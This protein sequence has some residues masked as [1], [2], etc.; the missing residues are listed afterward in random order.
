MIPQKKR[1]LRRSVALPKQLV[2]DAVRNAPR[3]VGD[4]FNR[5]V[6]ISL[7]EYVARRKAV[8]FEQAM[9]RMASDPA[10]R[11]ECRSIAQEFRVADMDGLKDD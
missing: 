1:T 2:D 9:A 7:Q 6:I 5:L 3:E 4:N 8:A 10:I 11:D